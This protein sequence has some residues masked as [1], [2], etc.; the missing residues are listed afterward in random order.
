M[1]FDKYVGFKYRE[2]GRVAPD[3]DCYGLV[4]LFYK[5]E[6]KIDLPSFDENYEATDDERITDLIAQYKEGWKKVEFPEVG[7]L[8]LFR[9]MGRETHL[10]VMISS[11]HFIHVREN[12]DSVIESIS[13]HR[14]NKR[15]SGFY[16]YV[17]NKSCLQQHKATVTTSGIPHPL[18][19]ERYTVPVP[20]GT[21]I[22]LIV[23]GINSKYNISEEYNSSFIV[24]LNGIPISK[25]LWDSTITKEE[26]VVE[27]R[28]VPGKGAVKLVFA[29][30]L[31]VFAAPLANFLVGG[32]T[33]GMS[34]TA[35]AAT[36]AVAKGAIT[37]GAMSLLRSAQKPKNRETNNPETSERQLMISGAQ[38]RANPYGAI[39]VILGKVRMTPVIGAQNYLTYENERDSYLSML[40]IWGFGPLY[41]SPDYKF[42]DVS[43]TNFEDY[44]ISTL[45]RIVEPT[46]SE[47]KLFDSLYGKDVDQKVINAVLTCAG[48]PQKAV[49]PGSWFETSSKQDCDSVTL[50]FHFP[51]GLRYVFLKGSNAGT[52]NGYNV[53]LEVQNSADG[54]NWNALDLFDCSD[55]VS[56]NV[57]DYE[58]ENYTEGCNSDSGYCTRSVP[59]NRVVTEYLSKKDAFT[60]NKTYQK[61]SS[62]SFRFIRVRRLTGANAEDDERYRFLFASV[63]QSATFTSN[64]RPAI[65][66]P[67]CKIAKTAIKIKASDQLNGS[68]E[69]FNSV[70]QSIAPIWT[71]TDWIDAPTSNPASLFIHV[72][73]HP[74]NPR[75]KSLSQINMQELADFYQYCNT[76]GFE[77]NSVVA[78]Q[79]SLM[80]VLK[81]IC[82]AGRA[83]P[84]QKD[85]KFTVVIDREKSISQHFTPHNSWGFE[86]VKSLPEI[87]HG[88]RVQYYDEDSDYQESE[89]IVYNSGYNESNASLFES[90]SFPGTT[91]KSLVIDN[92]RWQFAQGKL[93]PETYSLNVD[94]EYLICNKGDRV[95]VT[96]DVPLWG[97]GSGRI[98][99]KISNL[100]LELD[101]PVPMQAAK[102]YTIRIRT[103]IGGSQSATVVPV[104]SDGYYNIVTVI[105]NTAFNTVQN[106]D[107]FMF[108]EI[109]QEAQDLI[110]LG[111]E[112]SE[113]MTARLILMDYGVTGSYN[114]FKDYKKLTTKTIFETQITLPPTLRIESFG[115]KKPTITKVLSD[116]SV[117]DII[118]RGVFR[119]NMNVGYINTDF[120][121][122]I[123]HSVEI[124]Y[125]LAASTT[126]LTK[127]YLRVGY[128]S[129]VVAVKD[130]IV[131]EEYKM[132][133][134]YVSID[135][136]YGLWSD[137]VTHFIQGATEQ[138]DQ[139]LGFTVSPDTVFGKVKLEWTANLEQNIVEY[140]IRDDPNF[141]TDE[142]LI[143]RV[144]ALSCVVNSPSIPGQ[145]K[146]YYISAIN[147]FNRYSSGVAS[148]EYKVQAVVFSPEPDSPIVLVPPSSIPIEYEID[149]NLNVMIKV[150]MLKDS[151]VAFYEMRENKGLPFLEST[152]I[153]ESDSDYT[154]NLPFSILKDRK[155]TIRANLVDGGYSIR[156]GSIEFLLGNLQPVSDLTFRIEEPS[157]VL[158][159]SP[160]L[161]AN[162]YLLWI[163]EFGVARAIKTLTPNHRLNIPK[164]DLNIKVVA[165]TNSGKFSRAYD[166]SI[167][168]SGNYNRNEIVNV[169]IN[170]TLG[171][172]VGFSNLSSSVVE[173]ADLL[174]SSSI[175]FPITNRDS[176][177]YSS[178][179]YNIENFSGSLLENIDGSLFKDD[180]WKIK[181]GYYESPAVDLGAVLTGYLVPTLTKVV[182]FHGETG[183]DHQR[184]LGEYLAEYTDKDISNKNAFLSV[185][186]YGVSDNP[187]TGVWKEINYGEIS[188]CRYVK[189]IIEALDI[190]PLT[191]VRIIAGSIFLDV[192]DKTLEGSRSTSSA[193]EYISV[194]DFNM[195]NLVL[196]STDK[197]CRSWVNNVTKDGFT[198][199]HDNTSHPTLLRYFVK[200]Y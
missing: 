19:T 182:E 129:G 71:G 189:M 1:S 177:L 85:G 62:N 166:T 155:Y 29:L 32:L 38:N 146:T 37:L 199:N 195:I 59:V 153:Y 80:D 36:L 198:I 184:V 127:K 2:K 94:I 114:I 187:A 179:G 178:F 41:I 121:P 24:M 57:I 171:K 113:N 139:V 137:P 89:V 140:E 119:Y 50:S 190:G 128:S 74:A 196:V 123:T 11:S 98:K 163:E 15:I 164:F 188:T 82:I 45:P 148:F 18:R 31:I 65:D 100:V 136:R 126:S 105:P 106:G 66:P 56:K 93:R 92:A 83:T 144:S 175:T 53:R 183:L 23:S 147:S 173:K 88:L 111:I 145:S 44:T 33:F 170:M 107:L 159:W 69:G 49:Q 48:D 116:S 54:V 17:E 39:P 84:L 192:P 186:L 168:V 77:Y 109:G 197:P 151:N 101:E 132:R 91:K 87:P 10:G 55:L 158:E 124:E 99:N 14:W 193:S 79:K 22:S 143:T 5:E 26:D 162:Y 75:R 112:S 63:F 96:H 141:G 130:L 3:L 16:R 35:T 200:G 95:K 172:F 154:F 150:K 58:T 142:G 176:S 64:L 125:D 131:G 72:L 43:L 68:I 122:N 8:I 47:N 42:G 25:H 102:P 110:V 152:V 6:L 73:T 60:L 181:N 52:S 78:T 169:P 28:C 149:S 133:L 13:T 9:V 30:A 161:E 138:P 167:D 174:G 81:E 108:G 46:S 61:V 156:E 157:L 4:R 7:D 104:P 34:A 12:M 135:G 76:K 86:G 51:E 120:L 103:S 160:V 21:K 97:I 191:R 115:E 194:S 20:V 165:A 27:Y 185:K 180:F 70:V 90:M 117:M 134:R 40:L 118:S 67:N